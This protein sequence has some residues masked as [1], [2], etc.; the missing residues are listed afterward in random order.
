MWGR[1]N[2]AAEEDV[3]TGKAVAW[4]SS[5]RYKGTQHVASDLFLIIF[6]MTSINSNY[7]PINTVK[8][9]ARP[10]SRRCGPCQ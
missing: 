8:T 6:L 5:T 4:G 1:D 3:T 7:D 9:K 2:C 10:A